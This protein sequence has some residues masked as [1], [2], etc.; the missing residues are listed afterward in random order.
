MVVE[1]WSFKTQ[2][3]D[4]GDGSMRRRVYLIL[5]KHALQLVMMVKGR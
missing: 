2:T 4:A 3:W 1:F 5:Q